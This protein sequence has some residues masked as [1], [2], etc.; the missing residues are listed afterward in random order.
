MFV[1]YLAQ[2]TKKRVWDVCKYNL[3]LGFKNITKNPEINMGNAKRFID[4]YF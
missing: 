1:N 4:K 3:D 2:K